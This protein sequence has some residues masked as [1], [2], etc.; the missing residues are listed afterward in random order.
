MKH[1]FILIFFTT[2]LVQLS[3][4]QS[5]SSREALSKEKKY[6]SLDTLASLYPVQRYTLN[7]MELYGVN[8][9]VEVYNVFVGSIIVFSVLP[10]FMSESNW[11]VVDLEDIRSEFLDAGYL[12]RISASPLVRASETKSMSFQLVKQDSGKYWISNVCLTEWF[13]PTNYVSDDHP[14]VFNVRKGSLNVYQTPLMIREMMEV[15]GKTP[16]L[17]EGWPFPLD[18]RKGGT[19]LLNRPRMEREYLSREFTIQNQ[20]AYQM[21]TLSDWSGF[22]GYSYHRGVDR[23]IYMPSKGIVGGSYDF[24]FLYKLSSGWNN[25]GIRYDIRPRH[26]K[27][28]DELWENVIEEK[29]MIAEELKPITIE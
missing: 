8:E 14:S 28:M 9:T 24:Y 17:L 13:V 1:Y 25:P 6:I 21:W 19:L 23:F 16:G 3:Y 26:N 27:T 18:F 4:G 7:T 20:P 2:F 22:E 10:D 5:S 15:F 29:V 12:N 11:T